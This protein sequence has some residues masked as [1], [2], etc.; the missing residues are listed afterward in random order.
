MSNVLDRFLRYVRYDTTA[1]ERSTTYPSTPGQ[2]VLL[3]DLADE[4]RTIGLAD[5]TMD[6]YGYVMATIPATTTRQVPTIGF[7][8]HVDTSPEMSGTNVQADRAS[9]VRR[10]RPRAARR[11]EPRADA[12]PTIPSSPNSWDT[13]SSRRRARR[14]SVR[15]TR[16]AWPR[17]SPPPNTSFAHPE[18]PHGAIRIAFTPDEEVGPRHAALRCRPLR[19]ASARTRWTAAAAA[20]S[21]A[22]ASPPMR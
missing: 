14:C 17:S 21:R 11:S 3:R 7:I 19:R 2:L 18:I 5:V 22:R 1:D 9:H 4:L 10:A 16:P 8:A 12:S 6:E 20:R 15:T 13:T